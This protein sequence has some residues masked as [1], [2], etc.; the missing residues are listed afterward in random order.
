[1]ASRFSTS[2]RVAI[3][4][5]ALVLAAALAACY[6]PYEKPSE[7]TGEY[8]LPSYS[9]PAAAESDAH[10]VAGHGEEESGDAPVTVTVTEQPGA[11]GAA[12]E[13]QAGG[14]QQTGGAAQ[15]QMLGQEGAQGAVP[16]AA[17]GQQAQVPAGQ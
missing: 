1:M 5:P 15:Q 4:A 14:E 10:G 7:N 3:A 9:E 2:T 16:G 6:P 17:G 13:Q 12:A 11:A 8:T